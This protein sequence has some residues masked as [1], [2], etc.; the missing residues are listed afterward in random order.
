MNRFAFIVFL[1]VN[2]TL[3]SA[4]QKD[5][6]ELEKRNGFK[7]IKLASIV[8]SVKGV[9]FKKDFKEKDIYPAKLYSVDHPDYEKIGEVKVSKIEL[10]AY[11]SLIYEISVIA[12]K[13]P[14]LM[15]A[16]ESLYGKSEY[17]IK[18]ETYFWKGDT[19]VLKFRSHGKHH[20]ELTYY[21]YPVLKLMKTDKE[22]KVD[23][24]ANDF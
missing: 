1:L 10:K 5:T 18:N 13:D 17:D 8:D 19:V 15:K 2:A 9:K 20:L 6:T 22:K 16:L 11:N 21:S 23:E 14:R 7:D 4:F 24:I 12:D 3:A